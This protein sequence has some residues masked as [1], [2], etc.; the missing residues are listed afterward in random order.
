VAYERVKPTYLK[1][2]YARKSI[3]GRAESTTAQVCSTPHTTQ[4]GVRCAVITEPVAT[5]TLMEAIAP[6]TCSGEVSGSNTDQV[7]YRG[8]FM[9]FFGLSG[10]FLDSTLKKYHTAPQPTTREQ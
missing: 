2:A 8:I 9:K 5:P 10:E 3:I 1:L 6:A 4:Q 7:T